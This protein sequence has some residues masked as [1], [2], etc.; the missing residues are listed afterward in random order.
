MNNID[1][2]YEILKLKPNAL[3]EEVKQAYRDLAMVWHPDRFPADNPRLKEKAQEELK[4]IN[5]AYEVIKSHQFSYSANTKSPTADTKNDRASATNPKPPNSTDA[6]TYYEQGMEQAKRGK[7]KEAIADFLRAIL[8]NPN[9]A[10][11]Y[12]YRGIAHSKVGDNQKA[13]SD[14]KQA[15]NLYLKQGNTNNY[16]DVLEW[17]KKLQPPEPVNTVETSYFNLQELL[18]ARRWREADQETLNIMLKLAGREKEGWLRV[19]DI[20]NFPSTHLKTLDKLW[21]KSSKGHFGFT[22]QKRILQMS[23]NCGLFGYETFDEIVGWRVKGYLNEKYSWLVKEQHLRFSMN[24]P[25]GHLPVKW[26][27]LNQAVCVEVLGSILSRPDL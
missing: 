14:L 24:A 13:I 8:I 27:V 5:A 10:E 2:C 7:Y 15:A 17:L 20:K 18:L 22:V 19:E 25:V 9:Y 4:R 6:K 26:C 16:Q 12:K 21:V 1:Q 11:A 3:P 23:K